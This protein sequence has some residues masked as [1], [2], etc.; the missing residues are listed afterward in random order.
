MALKAGPMIVQEPISFPCGAAS[1]RFDVPELASSV[2]RSVQNAE[3]AAPSQEVIG[4][5]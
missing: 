2:A 4:A 5:G 1:N 3:T